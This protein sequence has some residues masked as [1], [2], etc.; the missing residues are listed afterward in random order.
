MTWFNASDAV[1][2]FLTPRNEYQIIFAH[3]K[4]KPEKLEK[5]IV[6]YIKCVHHTAPLLFRDNQQNKKGLSVDTSK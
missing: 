5:W 6:F 2:R 4:F 3:A 1:L